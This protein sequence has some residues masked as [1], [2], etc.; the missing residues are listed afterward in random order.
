MADFTSGARAGAPSQGHS[1]AP[2]N[3]PPHL[4]DLDR[5]TR[6]LQR[7]VLLLALGWAVTLGW[8]VLQGSASPHAGVAE[9]LRAERLEIVEPDGQ[10]AFVLTNSHRPAPATID[11][12]VIMEGQEEERRTPSF[13]FFDGKGDEVGG[14][15]FRTGDGQDGP[16]ATRHLSLDGYKQDQTVVLAHYQ[17]PGGSLSGLLVSD[18]PHDLSILDAMAELGLEPGAGRQEL[19]AA[20]MALPEE[21]RDARLRELF[22]V[23]RLFV[24][25]S[26]EGDAALT[27][28]DGQGRLR[29]AIGVPEEGAPYI[30]VLDEAGEVVWELP[31][32]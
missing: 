1:T 17:D 3:L 12:Q 32:G 15:L 22:G 27:L 6:R 26:R 20:V 5:R 24:G 28:R 18:R 13:I 19:Q 10:L 16:S 21:G 30:R 11:G 14:M 31:E 23:S 8:I 9:V 29:L 2:R 4:A 25:S 7:A